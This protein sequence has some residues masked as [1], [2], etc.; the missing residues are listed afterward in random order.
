MTAEEKEA[1]NLVVEHGAPGGCGRRC[2]GRTRRRWR[3]RGGG[4]GGRGRGF[5]GPS[6][7]TEFSSEFSAL[8]SR[9][10]TVLEIRDFL[11]GDSDEFNL[12]RSLIINRLLL[13]SCIT[14]ANLI[15]QV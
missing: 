10:M 5:G 13:L 4:G 3:R 7:P 1:A 15:A 9:H 14:Q 2:R 11:S 6:L 12:H 8:L